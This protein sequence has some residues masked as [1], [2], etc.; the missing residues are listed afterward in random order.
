MSDGM[1]DMERELAVK[2]EAKLRAAEPSAQAIECPKHGAQPV[3]HID[4]R[5]LEIMCKE[6]WNEQMKEII[7]DPEMQEKLHAHIEKGLEIGVSVGCKPSPHRPH[8][9]ALQDLE[10]KVRPGHVGLWAVKALREHIPQVDSRAQRL[11]DDIEESMCVDD[12][13]AADAMNSG[14]ERIHAVLHPEGD[15]NYPWDSDIIDRVAE[16][17]YE[18]IPHPTSE[19]EYAIDEVLRDHSNLCLDED[20]ERLRVRDALVEKLGGGS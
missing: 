4:D 6:C 8:G 1:T 5:G 16:I 3:V 15:P 17:V 12:L 9:E 18:F 11:L 19:L 10:E 7:Q 13:E 20:E 2:R 14:L